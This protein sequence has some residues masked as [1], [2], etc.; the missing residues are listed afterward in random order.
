MCGVPPAQATA[1]EHGELLTIDELAARTG[2]TVRTIRFYAAEGL[3]PAPVRQGRLAYYGPAH[4]MRL[5]FVR[6]LQ[7]HGYTLA[8]IDRVLSRIPADVSAA[9]L[10]LHRALLAPWA[11]EPGEELDPAALRQRAGR[12]LDDGA[13]EFLVAMGA[14]EPCAEGRYRTTSSLLAL[15]IELLDLPV[16]RSALVEAGAVISHHAT[17]AAAELTEVFRRGIWEPYRRG[18]LDQLGEDRLA[19]VIARM[20]PIALQTLVTAFERAADRA[21]REPLQR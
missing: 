15:G 11:P 10:A 2:L 21:I 16:P 13:L 9:D 18:E 6:E 1:T 3:L 7:E 8:A 19:A 20:R 14:L 12:P 5:D 17:A 4:R